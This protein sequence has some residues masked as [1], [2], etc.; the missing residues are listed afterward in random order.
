MSWRFRLALFACTALGVLNSNALALAQQAEATTVTSSTDKTEDDD[1]TQLQK[2]VIKGNRIQRGSISDSPLVSRTPAATL[3]KKQVEDLKDFG[4]T[5]DSGITYDNASK[6]VNIRGLEDDRV[7]TLMDGIPVPYFFDSI[8]SYGG[9]ADTYDFT[10]LSSVDVLKSADSSRA[11]SGA[12]GGALLLHS[13]EPEDLIEPGETYGGMV[14]LGFDGSDHSISASGAIAANVDH[15]SI[16]FQSSYKYGHE[17]ETNG[18]VGGTG[19]SRTIADPKDYNQRN[20]LFK[21]RQELEGGNTI[22]LTAEHYGYNSTKNYLSYSGYGTTYSSYDYKLDK[23][24]DRLSIDYKYEADSDRDWINSGFATLYWQRSSRTEGTQGYRLTSPKGEYDRLMHSDEKDYGY[25]TWANSNFDTGALHHKLTFGSDFQL[26]QSSYYL[27]GVDSCST[28]YVSSCSYYHTNESY[29][30][31]VNSY[32]FGAYVEDKITLGDSPFSFTPGLRFDWY[33]QD[34]QETASYSGDMPDGQS[35]NHL[36]PKLRAAW[37]ATPDTEVYLQF[38]TAYKSPNAYQL[39]VDYDNSP[40]YRYIG[41]PDLKPETSW[42][43]EGGVNFGDEDFGAHLNAFSTRYKNFIDTTLVSTSGYSYGSYE[44]VNVDNVRI[45]GISLSG[46]KKFDSGINLH[47]SVSYA[48]GTNLDTDELLS[49]VPPV[50]A[51]VGVGYEK[52][53]WGTDLTLVAAGAVSQKSSASSKPGGYAILNLTG[54][55]QPAELKGM[56]VQAGIYNLLNKTYYDALEVKDVTNLTE[57]YSESGR[58]IKIAVSQ[59]F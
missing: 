51:I 28:D 20:L 54:W 9:G 14:K 12:L 16:L 53:S 58:Y 38:V 24:R 29:A 2:I 11:G 18:E 7:L 6:S 15:T 25:T 10:S 3:L 34:P 13:L 52:D 37:Q 26:A 55:W 31:D 49:S 39:Y 17:T 40:L 44:F 5:I 19:S 48:R 42:G 45:S 35:G 32:K 23:S 27:S 30:P 59:K 47:G 43:F 41:N 8:Y 4:N 36:S 1:S 50:K 21:V 57:L 22:G 56:T 46:Q 33:K